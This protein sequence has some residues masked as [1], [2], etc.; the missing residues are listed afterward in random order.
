[1]GED[2]GKARLAWAFRPGIWGRPISWGTAV[3]D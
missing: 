2:V 1:V 3:L